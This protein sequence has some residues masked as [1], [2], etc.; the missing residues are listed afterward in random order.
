MAINPVRCCEGG[1]VI[2][3][4]SSS[5]P[6]THDKRILATTNE[7]EK[8]MRCL[9]IFLP[10]LLP[11]HSPLSRASCWRKSPSIQ[12]SILRKTISIKIVCG[13]IQPQKILPK[14]AVKRI[15]NM[16][17]AIKPTTKIA[18]S[19]GPKASPKKIN[20][21]ASKLNNIN[22]CPF[23]LM[24][25]ITTRISISSAATT[26]RAEVNLPFGFLG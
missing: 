22:G 11:V 16:A 8:K 3:L 5:T 19:Y 7:R 26:V 4:K 6:T 25:G 21:R 12:N 15:M 18:K 9:R 1:S 17:K 2:I 24:N 23:T 20:F 13:Q 14:I 10:Y